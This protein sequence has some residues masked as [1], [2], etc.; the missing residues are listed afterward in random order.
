MKARPAAPASRAA[1]VGANRHASFSTRSGCVAL[2]LIGVAA[3][4]K[5]AVA[6]DTAAPAMSGT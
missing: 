4:A 2:L 3:A 1:A 6:A 5:A